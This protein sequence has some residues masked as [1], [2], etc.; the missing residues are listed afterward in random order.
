MNASSLQAQRMLV[1]LIEVYNAL[2][3]QIS[4]M[5]SICYADLQTLYISHGLSTLIQLSLTGL[6]GI[7]V[8]SKDEHF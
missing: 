6:T 7:D 1:V 4:F 5:P 8:Y 2:D 3:I